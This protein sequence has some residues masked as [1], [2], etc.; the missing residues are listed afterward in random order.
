MQLDPTFIGTVQDVFGATVTVELSNETVTG[1]TFLKGEAYKIGQV[2]SFVRIP[3]GFV[4][5][6]GIVSQV[7][8]GAAPENEPDK[9][10][11]N[12]WLKV[13]LVGEG[14]RN[15][16]FER[17]ISQ[18]PTIEDQ[19]H[20]VTESDLKNIYGTGDP[21]DYVSVGHL[22][23]AESIPALININKL[24]NRHSAVVGTT[25]SGKSTTVAGLLNALSDTTK[26]PSSRVLIFD[27][28]GEYSKAL[29]DRANIFR[30]DA[31]KSKGQSEFHI[32]YWAL[33]FDEFVEI[34]FGKLSDS[35]LSVVAEQ[36]VKLKKEANEINKVDGIETHRISVDTPV[37][38][39]IHK[40]WFELHVREHHTLIP[41]PGGAADDL[42]YAYALNEDGNPIQA[43][44]ALSIVPP[45]F[46]TPKTSGPAN[47]RVQLGRDGVGIR[48]QLAG[49][50]AKLRD[51]RFNFIFNP[52][53]WL[54]DIEGKVD[55]DLDTL[56]EGWIGSDKPI[57]ILDL[58]GTPSITL[59]QIIG[60]LIR[61]VYDAVFWARNLSEGGRERPLLLVLE[62]AHAY[63][64]K[65]NANTAS[66]AVKKI[67]KEGRKYGVGM[68]II[69]QRPSEI[70]ST[71]LSQCGTFFA[72]RLTNEADR[73]HIMSAAS[74]NLKGIFEML[75]I[76][77]TGEAIVVGESVSLPIRALIKPPPIDRRPDSVDPK[78][79]EKG[80]LEDGF[81]GPGGWGQQR[82]PSN[83]SAMVK[84][85][86]MQ[87]P[88]YS[89]K[90][91]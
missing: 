50:A 84:Q 2:G 42:E 47:E 18:Y 8:A 59:T 26:Y 51:P 12:R 80:N 1:L 31:D 4:E 49:L 78:V 7:G 16:N 68:M 86:R 40:L 91:K 44:D 53:G 60:S 70:D 56:L 14:Q 24:I 37:P 13:Q 79:V 89:I 11:G 28:H 23:S 32:P 45:L 55:V 73:G 63:L 66:S 15:G 76:L 6:Y 58:S 35:A 41:R 20:I 22:A 30:V 67:A 90:I 74:D 83:Y 10:F 19:V 81:D 72:L 61:V 46:R 17:G 38:F 33:S 62:E 71:I 25:G 64:N 43:G 77:R 21:Q 27:I 3:L 29:S 88:H 39:C 36:V 75:P 85:W 48:Q 65:E 9:Q 87:S 5:L 82:S 57:T 69:S 34:A 52:E 54:P